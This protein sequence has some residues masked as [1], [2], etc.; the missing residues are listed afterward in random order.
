VARQ[1]DALLVENSRVLPRAF[2]P[3]SVTVGMQD[4]VAVDQMGAHHDFGE[5]AWITANVVP[6]DRLNGPGR[7]TIRKTG[8]GYTIVADMQGDGWIVVSNTAWKG[9]RAYVNGKRTEIQRAN[10]AFQSVHV[11]GG[12]S[13][14]RLVYRP[15][16][17]VAGRAISFGTLLVV[18]AFAFFRRRVPQTDRLDEEAPATSNQQ[19][20]TRDE[21]PATRND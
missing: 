13:E 5:R 1:G 7:A 20:A 3:Q 8:D 6:Y 11:G 15:Q 2:V 17:F 4:E 12:R 9:W 14:V 18:L 10:V 21:E 16:S 19:P